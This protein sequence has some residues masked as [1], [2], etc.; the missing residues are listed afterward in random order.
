MPRTSLAKLTQPSL[1]DMMHQSISQNKMS[2]LVRC[3]WHN[4]WWDPLRGDTTGSKSVF[5]KCFSQLLP[6]TSAEPSISNINLSDW[7]RGK[8]QEHSMVN[9]GDVTPVESFHNGGQNI[10]N[11]T[12][13]TFSISCNGRVKSQR[14][15]KCKHFS[16]WPM[17][18]CLWCQNG[19]SEQVEL[20][21]SKSFIKILHIIRVK[22][23]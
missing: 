13:L 11:W 8:D 9:Q 1:F 16:S 4:N 23:F 6:L 12:K 14:W 18:Y 21:C 5:K 3:E 20:P 2:K 10:V 15:E 17:V 7:G 19:P 22:E